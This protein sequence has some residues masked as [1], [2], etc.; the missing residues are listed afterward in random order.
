MSTHDEALHPRETTGR[1]ATKPVDEVAGG[2][3][4]LTADI[5]PVKAQYVEEAAAVGVPAGMTYALESDD[6]ERLLPV[7]S[8]TDDRQTRRERVESYCTCREAWRT[9][10]PNREGA[11]DLVAHSRGQLEAAI[12][13]RGRLSMADGEAQISEAETDVFRSA[14]RWL[15]ACDDERALTPGVTPHHPSA[16]ARVT[17]PAYRGQAM[18][19]PERS[20]AAGYEVPMVSELRELLDSQA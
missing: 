1:F 16:T 10:P 9:A 7:L 19:Y 2:L 11:A 14:Q 13:R 15:M 18:A 20:D 3:S 4:A 5:D 12:E 6:I 17:D 8:I